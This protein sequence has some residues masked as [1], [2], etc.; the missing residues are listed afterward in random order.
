MIS[1]KWE[2]IP[3]EQSKDGKATAFPLLAIPGAFEEKLKKESSI[4]RAG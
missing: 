4:G 3:Q 1:Y 2:D